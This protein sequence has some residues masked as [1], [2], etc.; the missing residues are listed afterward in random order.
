MA[1]CST[2]ATFQIRRS[3][4]DL[5]ADGRL[6][7]ADEDQTFR[8]RLAQPQD[9]DVYF[10][11]QPSHSTHRLHV[12]PQQNAGIFLG[13]PRVRKRSKQHGFQLNY[14]NRVEFKPLG[15]AAWQ[16]LT[17]TSDLAGRFRVRC[18]GADNEV[19]FSR[20][21]AVLPPAFG[22]QFDVPGRS[23][24]F[25]NTGSLRLS[26]GADSG[27]AIEREDG[28]LPAD[29]GRRV[30]GAYYADGQAFGR[31]VIHDPLRCAYRRPLRPPV[32]RMQQEKPM[33]QGAPNRRAG[34]VR[35]AVGADQPNG[36]N[37]DP[38]TF[39]DS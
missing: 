14:T 31:I 24:L 26:V 15:K 9:D 7:D 12:C 37:P 8:I 28:A 25:A 1:T 10:V 3:I 23:L 27:A 32:F 17:S 20:E 2:G 5:T 6:H 13:F 38:A 33:K 19:L 11:L 16:P 4:Y 30:D 21:V 22:I 34:A 39:A 29:A 36:A 18:I 35:G